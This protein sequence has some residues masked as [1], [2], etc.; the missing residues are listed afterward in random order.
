MTFQTTVN[1]TYAFGVVGELI[2]DG[3]L[4]STRRT[5][6]SSGVNPNNIGYVFIVDATTG[7]A[8]VGGTIDSTHL[9]GGILACPKE[10]S[11]S[12]TTAGTLAPTMALPDNTDGDLL[13]MG[14]IVIN[15]GTACNIG[16]LLVYDTTTG[17]ISTVAAGS[18]SAGSGK[19]F[20]PNGTSRSITAAPGLIAARLTN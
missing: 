5:L 11:S 16:D 15:T 10:Y 7:I 4:R 19:A 9:F 2:H 1:T 14:T 12:G 20:V 8:R 18:G 13:E 6:N 3:P 17:A